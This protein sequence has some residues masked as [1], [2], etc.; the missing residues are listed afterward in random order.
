MKTLL[1]LL[2]LFVCPSLAFTQKQK[3]ETTAL[4][5]IE[6]RKGDTLSVFRITPVQPGRKLLDDHFYYWYRSDS[7]FQTQGAVSGKVLHGEYAAY[8]P[9]KNLMESGK[10]VYGLKSGT[11]LTWRPNGQLHTKK[12]WKE[13][14]LNGYSYEYDEKGALINKQQ[15]EAGN[16][17][18]K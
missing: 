12:E 16:K 3:L 10:Y 18:T 8:Y 4:H 2:P 11:W 6:S 9:N 17:I 1:L 14:R 7:I 13:G 5:R 15:Y